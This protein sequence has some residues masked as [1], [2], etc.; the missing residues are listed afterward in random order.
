MVYD[1]YKTLDE[2]D[3]QTFGLANYEIYGSDLIEP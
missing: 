3:L 1:I 2:K